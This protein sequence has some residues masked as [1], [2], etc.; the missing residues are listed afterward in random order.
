MLSENKS[1]TENKLNLK[2]SFNVDFWQPLL[3]QLHCVIAVSVSFSMLC[4][5]KEK[6]NTLEETC[7]FTRTLQSRQLSHGCSFSTV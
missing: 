3:A 2:P 6:T 5:V 4:Y 7:F 1:G